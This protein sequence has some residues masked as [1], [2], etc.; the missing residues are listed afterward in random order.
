M[1]VL[2]R[3]SI[4]WQF[5]YEGLWK[6]DQ[7][8][9]SHPWTA[10][11]FLR[12]AQ[13]P[14]RD[15]YRNLTGDPDDQNW[16]DYQS[17]SDRWDKWR[18]SFASHFQLDES[19][20][21]RLDLLIDG[22]AEFAEKL[23]AVPEQVDLKR[24]SKAIRYDAEKKLLVVP[25]N[26]RLIPKEYDQLQSMVSV[27][28]VADD[29]L[30]GGTD[31]EQAFFVALER[32]NKRQSRLAY[33]EKLQVLLKGDPER[34]GLVQEEYKDTIDYKRPGE[35]D[36]YHDLVAR[37]NALLAVGEPA[38]IQRHAEFYA[39]KMNAARGKLIGPVKQLE[40]AMQSAALKQLPLEQFSAGPPPAVSSQMALIDTV[41][42]WSLIVLGGLLI[43]G[44]A[45]RISAVAAA[46][47]LLSFY[48]AYP[49]WPGIEPIAPGPEHSLIVNKNLIE[50][51]AL[52]AIAALP[53]GSWFGLDAIFGKIFGRRWSGRRMSGRD[54]QSAVGRV[55][56]RLRR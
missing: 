3:I 42:L 14:L 50:V 28:R 19:Q 23:D 55:E 33:R 1:I 18:E 45:T 47:L 7:Q 5:L 32:L 2:L 46:G 35:I 10:E 4:G 51:I 52:L 49:P 6:L 9:T 31:A 15:T 41:T 17:V 27:K 30:E 36:Q 25:G 34:M 54:R 40:A 21:S 38:F 24:F 13:G 43:L 37:Y 53:T 16:L 48:M 11:P 26:W 8:A 22:P 29:K 39:G 12:N 44:C 20:R 56:S